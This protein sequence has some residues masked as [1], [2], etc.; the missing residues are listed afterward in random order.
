MRIAGA[1][2]A[3]TVLLGEEADDEARS[4]IAAL[5]AGLRY[6]RLLRFAEVSVAGQSLDRVDLLTVSHGHQHK[7]AIDGH[8]AAAATG[9]PDEQHGAGAALALGAAFL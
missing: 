9:G 1:N 7:A 6:H 2:P 4:A 8:E 5:G 3:G